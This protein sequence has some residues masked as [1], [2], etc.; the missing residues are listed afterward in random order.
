[1]LLLHAYRASLQL[2]D[3]NLST[4]SPS[5]FFTW[6]LW[7]RHRVRH[8][9]WSASDEASAVPAHSCCQQRVTVMNS[10]NTGIHLW[11][12]PTDDANICFHDRFPN[13]AFAN[14]QF[15]FENADPSGSSSLW[16]L[17]NNLSFLQSK[18]TGIQ[19]TKSWPCFELYCG[20]GMF[21]PD[22][23]SEFFPSR[24]PDSK[25]FHTGSQIPDPH[26]RI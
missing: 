6:R 1:M 19:Y 22:P 16:R 7:W 13:A 18:H 5:R 12:Y 9:R 11:H 21:I 10:A 8:S 15:G 23:G 25:C 3:D 14:S 20:S 26:Q 2:Q 24:F 4:F 17:I